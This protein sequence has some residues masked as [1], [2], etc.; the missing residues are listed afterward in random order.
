MAPPH[1]SNINTKAATKIMKLIKWGVAMLVIAVQILLPAASFAAPKDPSSG[2]TSGFSGVP[3]A[4]SGGADLNRTKFNYQLDPSQEASDQ[5][6]IVNTGNTPIKLDVYAAD[7]IT[8]DAGGYSVKI[9]SEKSTDVGSWVK[10]KSG[11]N[12]VQVD[13]KVGEDAT[14]P[15]TLRVPGFASPGDHLGGIAVATRASQS[16][17]QIVIERR[18]VTRLYA[19]IRGELSPLLTV[20]NLSASYLHSF[21]PFEGA[22][23]EKF[24]IANVGNVSLK[25]KAT[26][27]VTG[28]FGIPL[29]SAQVFDVGEMSP[30]STRDFQLT[31]PSIGQWVF[32]HPTVKLTTFTDKDALDAGTLPV[33]V[34]DVILWIFP[35]TFVVAAIL[36]LIIAFIVRTNIRS[37]QQ[38]VKRWLAYAEAEARRNADTRA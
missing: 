20:S 31:V 22:L 32:L 23:T 9:S 2:K 36:L 27:E 29:T 30:G 16:T 26:A 3:G 11:K 8:D 33:V 18:V 4:K 19:R 14:I 38:Q 21:S 15:F 25:A 28:P 10:F 7:A 34:R 24:T 5:F 37:R 13:L 35:T 17:G 6:Y 12:L 1:S